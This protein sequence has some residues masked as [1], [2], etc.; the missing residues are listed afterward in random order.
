MSEWRCAVP[1]CRVSRLVLNLF[2]SSPEQPTRKGGEEGKL[3]RCRI[4]Q[5]RSMNSKPSGDPADGLIVA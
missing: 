3:K 5:S 4:G 2:F 1:A